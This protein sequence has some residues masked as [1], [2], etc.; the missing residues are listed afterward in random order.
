MKNFLIKYAPWLISAISTVG[1]I[2]NIYNLASCFFIWTFGN[3]CWTAL[4]LFN[5]DKRM[6]GQIT[7]WVVFSLVNIYGFYI[8]VWKNGYPLW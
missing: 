4:I 6:Y 5:K 7:I 3:A 8:W 1:C 2:L